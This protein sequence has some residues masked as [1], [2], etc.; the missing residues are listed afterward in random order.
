MTITKIILRR[1]K[2]DLP[3]EIKSC[4]CPINELKYIGKNKDGKMIYWCPKHNVHKIYEF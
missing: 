3:K 2:K 4:L 1:G